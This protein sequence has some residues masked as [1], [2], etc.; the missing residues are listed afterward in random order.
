LIR[1]IQRTILPRSRRRVK[2]VLVVQNIR[3]LLVQIFV[4]GAV[5]SLQIPIR[6]VQDALIFLQLLLNA[7][8]LSVLP[9]IS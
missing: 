3:Q 8:P 6:V 7:F 9:L 5:K 1:V 2:Y 4:L